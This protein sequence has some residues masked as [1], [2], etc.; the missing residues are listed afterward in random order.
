L[1]E[2]NSDVYPYTDQLAWTAGWIPTSGSHKEASFNNGQL[3]ILDQSFCTKYPNENESYQLCAGSNQLDGQQQNQFF[4]FGAN[5][6]GP[7]FVETEVAATA[8]DSSN[9]TIRRRVLVGFSM[10]P[11]AA[12]AV[13]SNPALFTRISFYLNWIDANRV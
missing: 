11:T 10:A 2:Q 7:L 8:T 5:S 6:S 3:I 1:P 4:C 13:C 12:S 9:T